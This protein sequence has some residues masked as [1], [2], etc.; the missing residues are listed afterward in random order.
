MQLAPRLGMKYL[1]RSTSSEMLPS[2]LCLGELRIR[3][4]GMSR[5]KRKMLEGVRGAG[6]SG[7]MGE[8]EWVCVT[9]VSGA[10]LIIGLWMMSG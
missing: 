5:S 7:S 3:P 1:V 9:L 10:R 2:F 6:R 8:W 4:S